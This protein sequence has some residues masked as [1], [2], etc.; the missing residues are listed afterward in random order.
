LLFKQHGKKDIFAHLL[1]NMTKREIIF[2]L[3]VTLLEYSFGITVGIG[4]RCMQKV[5]RIGLIMCTGIMFVSGSTIA[6][7]EANPQDLQTIQKQIEESA[8]EKQ[9]VNNEIAAI[10]KEIDSLNTYIAENQKALSATEKKMADLTRM[11]EEKKAEIVILEDHILARKEVMKKRLVALQHDN[12]LSFVIKVLF[13]AKNFNDFVERANAVSTILS[14]DKDILAEQQEDLR[15]IEEAKKEIDRQQEILNEERKVLAEKEAELNDNLTKRQ[16]T[17]TALQEKYNQINQQMALKEQEKANIE[18]QLKAAQ[19]K[20]RNEQE[21]ANHRAAVAAA[22]V[23]NAVA[24]PAGGGQELYVT[25]TAYSPEESGAITRLGYNIKENPNMKLIA[26]DPAVIPLGKKVWV[27]GYG[28][29]IAG[30][31]GSAIVG[32]KIDVLMPTKQ[33]ALSW[34]RKTVKVV[35]LD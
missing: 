5:K 24:Q 14:A 1:P 23:S 28:V 26:V 16:A 21:T 25:A 29:A 11:I 31:T 2:N 35:I 15:K 20:I 32:H 8:L 22:A 18:A 34:G 6:L 19:E 3:F 9:A 7:A 10:Q 4:G 13:D 33:A 27:E 12:K 17:L 30:D